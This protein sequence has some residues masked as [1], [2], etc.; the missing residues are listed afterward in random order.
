MSRNTRQSSE[1]YQ[2]RRNVTGQ[3]V[4]DAIAAMK[5]SLLDILAIEIKKGTKN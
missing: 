3:Y 1:Q 5:A 2:S 4:D